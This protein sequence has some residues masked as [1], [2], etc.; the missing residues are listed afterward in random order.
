MPDYGGERIEDIRYNICGFEARCT[1]DYF[2]QYFNQLPDWLRPRKRVTRNAVEPFNNLLNLGYEV[3]RRRVHI[4]IIQAHLDTYMGYLHS[5][6]QYQQDLV[7]DLM[8]PWRAVIEGFILNYHTKL[9]PDSFT[10][11]GTRSFLKQEPMHNFTKTLDRHIDNKR[12][13]YSYRDNSKTTRIRTAIKEDQKKL[14]TYL[15]K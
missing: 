3:V 12:I 4:A 11:H 1:K 8:E 6:R 5:T 7:Y 15:R 9:D 14:A 2:K 13:P 10:L